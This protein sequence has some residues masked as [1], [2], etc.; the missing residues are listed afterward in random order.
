VDVYIATL[1]LRALLSRLSPLGPQLA[2]H[3]AGFPLEFTVMSDV[4]LGCVVGN[5]LA[6]AQK[7]TIKPHLRERL[8]LA[9]RRTTPFGLVATGQDGRLSFV[10]NYLTHDS[11]AVEGWPPAMPFP[12]FRPGQRVRVSASVT[13][14]LDQ[15]V[16][17]FDLSEVQALAGRDA[18]VV[19][20]SECALLG[21][22]LVT[23]DGVLWA[24]TPPFLTRAC[25]A[26]NGDELTALTAAGCPF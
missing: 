6:D 13:G 12:A 10:P 23:L 15:E 26:D 1:L 19:E 25:P 21:L 18:V 7:T 8:A 22:V 20:H 17:A 9:S 4:A 5:R 2:A 24:F 14:L 11:D 16:H 3:L